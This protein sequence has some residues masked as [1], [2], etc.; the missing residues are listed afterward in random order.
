V[1]AERVHRLPYRHGPRRRWPRRLGGMLG[2]GALLAIGGWTAVQVIPSSPGAETVAVAPAPAATLEP[3]AEK[4]QP[5]EPALTRAQ[6]RQRAAAVDALR[7]R[8]YRPVRLAAYDPT[9]TLRVLIGRGD[10]G[11]RA[12]FFAGRR[13]IGNDA[14]TDSA[15]VRLVGSGERS[16]TLSYRLF[17]P[18]DQ[19]CC[20]KGGTVRVRF[21]WDGK[22]LD[23]DNLIPPAASRLAPG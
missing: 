12:F 2:T 16:A 8:G 14:L 13:Y 6:R 10:G 11:Q 3:A 15:R 7:Q 9:H 4:A 23:P 17:S 21:R 5:A 20:P 22:T 19:S 1:T 18:G